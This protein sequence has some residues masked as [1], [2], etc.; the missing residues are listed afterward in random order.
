MTSRVA[1]YA[2]LRH[3]DTAHCGAVVCAAT[4]ATATTAATS[5]LHQHPR[6]D[7]DGRSYHATCH[8]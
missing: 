7:G 1:T 8:A 6:W 5:T 3:N 2:T 4:S